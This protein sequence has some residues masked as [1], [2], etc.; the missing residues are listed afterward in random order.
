M[1]PTDLS[2]EFWEILGLDP[3][4]FEKCVITIEVDKPICVEIKQGLASFRPE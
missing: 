1:M 3:F 2:K 4:L